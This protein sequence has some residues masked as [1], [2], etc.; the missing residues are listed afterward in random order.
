MYFFGFVA[1]MAMA[2]LMALGLLLR[3]T[4]PRERPEIL[5]AVA[6]II[7]AWKSAPPR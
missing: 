4:T 6:K 3:G 5:T 2:G 1:I 7:R